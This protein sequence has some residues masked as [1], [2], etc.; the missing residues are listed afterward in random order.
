MLYAVVRMLYAVEPYSLDPY[1]L[2][3]YAVVRMLYAV[4]PYSLAVVRMRSSP[5]YCANI[6]SMA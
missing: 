6:A 5:T 2:E 1:S 4:E 3:P